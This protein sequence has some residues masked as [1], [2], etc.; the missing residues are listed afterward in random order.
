MAIIFKE[1]MEGFMR[2]KPAQCARE[3]ALKK[4]QQKRFLVA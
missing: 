2:P 3:L 1:E 4:I